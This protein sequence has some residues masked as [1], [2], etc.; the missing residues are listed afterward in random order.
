[1][2][3][4]AKNKIRNSNIELTRIICMFFIF[5]G[6][7]IGQSGSIEITASIN[8]YILIL[9]SHFSRIAVNIFLLI[10]IWFMVDKK[11]SASRAL[12]LYFQ[13]AVY[14]IPI[15]IAVTIL[16]FG[17]LSTKDILRGL[18]PFF[19]RALWF[20]SAYM[21]LMLFKPFLDKII[22]WNQNSLQSFICLLF[23]SISFISTLPDKQEGY[24]IDTVWFTVVYIFVAYLK[25][26]NK[27]N[28]KVPYTYLGMAAIVA[29]IALTSFVF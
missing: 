26:Y 12:N 23:V 17:E 18:F 20:A 19:G 10:G 3:L 6:H 24:V 13:L 14:C 5:S 8:D 2:G 21:T 4:E 29:Y 9:M 16:H 28:R 11:F 27:E 7:F 1:M 22:E 25:K 15:T